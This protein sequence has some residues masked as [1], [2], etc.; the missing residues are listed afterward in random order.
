MLSDIIYPVVG[1]FIRHP[2]KH[3]GQDERARGHGFTFG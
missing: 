3:T 1:I 2:A